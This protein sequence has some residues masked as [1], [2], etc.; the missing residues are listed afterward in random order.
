L[1]DG[2]S[3]SVLLDEPG[4]SVGIS[5]LSSI[6]APALSMVPLA[7]TS[8]WGIPSLSWVF[9]LTLPMVSMASTSDVP[10]PLLRCW[11]G[12]ILSLY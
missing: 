7:A 2:W 11:S 12:G 6:F 3:G 4:W 1:D 9:A 8:G 10:E 5:A